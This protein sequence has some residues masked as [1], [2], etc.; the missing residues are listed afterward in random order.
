MFLLATFSRPPH[1]VS[2]FH[3]ENGNWFTL[4]TC[5]FSEVTVTHTKSTEGK[6]HGIKRSSKQTAEPKAKEER[7]FS[8]HVL[9]F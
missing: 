3:S 2:T 5:G 7:S 9:M 8:D 6:A 1:N 4:L